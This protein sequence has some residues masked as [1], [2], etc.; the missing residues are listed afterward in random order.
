MLLYHQYGPI[1]QP[2]L[3]ERAGVPHLR[4][5]H[6]DRAGGSDTAGPQPSGAFRGRRA[7]HQ[8]AGACGRLDIEKGVPHQLVGL[9]RRPVQPGRVYLPEVQPS[10]GRGRG[11]RYERRPA[12]GGGTGARRAPHAGH[13][14]AVCGRRSLCVRP[15]GDGG[16]HPQAEPRPW[17]YCR[18]GAPAARRQRPIGRGPGRHGAGRGRQAGCNKAGRRRP[19]RHRQSGDP[20]PPQRRGPPPIEG[21]PQ[22]APGRA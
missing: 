4:L 6:G 8:R 5:R 16:R 9:Q 19:H 14:A 15:G 12:R 1:R 2:R 3:F 21:V 17:A 18:G 13:C 7:A 11:G 10:L 22:H 20:G